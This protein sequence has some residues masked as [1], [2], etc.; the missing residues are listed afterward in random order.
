MRKIIITGST[1]ML[2]ASLIRAFLPD[3]AF[4]VIGLGRSL[5]SALPRADQILVDFSHLSTLEGLDI[6]ADVIIHTAALTD[7]NACESNPQL[8]HAINAESPG[9]LARKVSAA[10]VFFY[11][12]TDSVFDGRKGDYSESDQPD[13]LNVYAHTKLK[14][15]AATQTNCPDSVVVRTNIYGFHETMRNS[16]VEWAYREWSAGK[17]ISGFTDVTFN[18]LYTGQLARIIKRMVDENIRYPIL[19]VASNEA[20]SKFQ[21]LDLLRLKL[22]VSEPL[23]ASGS[24]TSFPSPIKR[25]KNT[26]LNISLLKSFHEA[27]S[28]M[29]GLDDC[30]D[31]QKK[32]NVIR[33]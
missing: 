32:L 1:G 3:R 7:L 17:R 25:P 6:K 15:E 10:G 12:S 4:Q 33:V 28:L 8:A 9:V 27:P 11:I 29:K 26:S 2:G 20:V 13:P 19:N 14:G 16:L 23:L 5:T 18:A 22:G 24:T 30:L 21:F 31:E